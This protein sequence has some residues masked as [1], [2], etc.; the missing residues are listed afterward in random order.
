MKQVGPAP[1]LGQLPVQCIERCFIKTEKYLCGYKFRHVPCRKGTGHSEGCNYVETFLKRPHFNR[2]LQEDTSACLPGCAAH[3]K[4]FRRSIYWLSPGVC[5]KINC[6]HLLG[7]KIASP[8]AYG[9]GLL[10]NLVFSYFFL[11]LP[12]H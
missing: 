1:A 10:S 2:D 7:V 4:V 5:Y 3:S 12:I 6:S 11:N 9:V 8:S